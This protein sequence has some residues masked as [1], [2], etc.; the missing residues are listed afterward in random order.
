MYQARAEL[1]FETPQEFDDH[2]EKIDR[3]GI[4]DNCSSVTRQVSREIIDNITFVVFA[5]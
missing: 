3:D 2:F 1:G 5:M 4:K